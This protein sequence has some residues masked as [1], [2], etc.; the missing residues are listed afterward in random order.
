MPQA[1]E[2]GSDSI[3]DPASQGDFLL[4]NSSPISSQFSAREG[5]RGQQMSSSQ[6]VAVSP[7]K[8]RRT[9]VGE[10]DVGEGGE[11]SGREVRVETRLARQTY[12]AESAPIVILSSSP[13]PPAPADAPMPR[14]SQNGNAGGIEDIP[15]QEFADLPPSSFPYDDDA[16]LSPPSWPI[17]VERSGR[18]RGDASPT[19]KRRAAAVTQ[20]DS[21]TEDSPDPVPV[22]AP[23]PKRAKQMGRT[24]SLL[25]ALDNL[26]V[27]DDSITT[28]TNVSTSKAA[29]AAAAKQARQAK[30]RQREAAKAIKLRLATEKKRFLEVN[31]LRTSK[32]DAMR[33]LIIDLDR[34]L[35]TPGQVLEKCQDSVKARF[36][37]EGA[38]VNLCHGVVEPP[39]VR[40]RRKWKADWDEGRRCW[41]PFAEGGIKVRREGMVVVMMDAKEVVRL[42]REEG[43]LERWY[44]DLKRRV[45]VLNA[46]RQGKGG[47]EQ[48]FLICQGLVK[49][50][51]RLKANENRAYTAR[52]R[53]QLAENQSDNPTSSSSSSAANASTSKTSTRKPN[54]TTDNSPPPPPPPPTISSIPP[55]TIVERSLLTLKLIHRCYIIH[56]SSL[57]DSIEWLHQLTS[58]LSLKPYKSLR[59]TH[60]SFSVDTG[61]NTTSSSLAGIY[62]MML[63]QIPRVTPAIAQSIA[64]IY[65]SLQSLIKAYEDCEG[66]EKEERGLLAGVRVQSNKD[67]TERRGN[68]M[69]LGKELSKRVR[70]VVRGRNGDAVVSHSSKD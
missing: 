64:T 39:L 17:R 56:A 51:S 37:E 50:Y 49:Y 31:R 67:G 70:E 3:I 25:D 2:I 55:Q 41:V 66:D 65:P 36:E 30:S 40:F 69:N 6:P 54:S 46:D 32:S 59:D 22:P 12:R 48:V 19:L 26:Y 34:T 58:D 45:G 47:E 21:A 57:V 16:A 60:L 8:T 23:A 33:E 53:Q 4:P 15:E 20:V 63:Q 52:I 68:R 44:G 10:R 61:R 11:E 24:T 1:I 62:T 38:E 28:T 7:P 13:P 9:K 14:A 43:G 5:G 27:P 35:F 42:V 18:D 29:K